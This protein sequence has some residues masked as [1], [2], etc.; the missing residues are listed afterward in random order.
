[1]QRTDV[2]EQRTNEVVSKFVLA[3]WWIVRLYDGGN[4][5]LISRVHCGIAEYK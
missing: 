2:H 3:V 1:M 4:V 5:V